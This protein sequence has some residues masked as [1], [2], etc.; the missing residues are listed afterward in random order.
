LCLKS[1]HLL[2]PHAR[3]SGHNLPEMLRHAAFTSRVAQRPIVSLVA[4]LETQLRGLFCQDKAQN[5]VALDPQNYPHMR[6]LR[7]ASDWPGSVQVSTN[8]QLHAV[9]TILDQ[10]IA[11]IRP[12][13][14]NL[15]I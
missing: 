5:P 7:H 13:N 3:P 9:L 8:T 11:T 10:I 6:Y 15:P 2:L 12:P 1:D 4:Q 14:T